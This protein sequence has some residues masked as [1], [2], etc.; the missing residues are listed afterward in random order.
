MKSMGWFVRQG[1]NR[2]DTGRYHEDLQRGMKDKDADSCPSLDGTQ[3]SCSAARYTLLVGQRIWPAG[4]A[5]TAA[6]WYRED[7]Q[8]CQ[9]GKGAAP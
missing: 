7:L 5:Q 4:K 6:K 8:R 3:Y 1:A 2:G 9:S